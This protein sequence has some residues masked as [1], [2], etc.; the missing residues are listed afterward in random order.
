MPN[1][2]ELLATSNFA[3]SRTRLPLFH[4]SLANEMRS[5]DSTQFRRQLSVLLWFLGTI[6]N[7][8]ISVMFRYT[9]GRCNVESSPK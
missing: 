4:C 3:A 1:D 5:R 8:S 7:G 2:R 6:V 9:I